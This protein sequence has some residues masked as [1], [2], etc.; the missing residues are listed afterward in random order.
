MDYVI[1]R[2]PHVVLGVPGVLFV[3]PPLFSAVDTH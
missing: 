2:T 1:E 3:N